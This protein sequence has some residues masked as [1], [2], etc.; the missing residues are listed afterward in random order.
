MTT[1][2]IIKH[3]AATNK[4]LEVAADQLNQTLKIIDNMSKRLVE[5]E[6]NFQAL[7]ERL[8]RTLE[9]VDELEDVIADIQED[10]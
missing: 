3:A 9:R 8:D 7:D 10:L 1:Q 4:A 5:L 2:E 6:E